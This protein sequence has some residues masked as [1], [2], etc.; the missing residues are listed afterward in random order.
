MLQV[1]KKFIAHKSKEDNEKRENDKK[2]DVERKRNQVSQIQYN[3][4]QFQ[5]FKE[6]NKF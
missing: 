2:M 3:Q 1:T 4:R 5:T 6:L